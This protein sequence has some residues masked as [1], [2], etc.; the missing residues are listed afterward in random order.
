MSIDVVGID[1]EYILENSVISIKLLFQNVQSARDRHRNPIGKNV[2]IIKK[3][4]DVH[5][6][7]FNVTGSNYVTSKYPKFRLKTFFKKCLFPLI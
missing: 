7:F 4:G 3:K 6:V 1:F 2:V 5:Y